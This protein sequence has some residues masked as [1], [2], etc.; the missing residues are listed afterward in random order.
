MAG[1]NQNGNLRFNGFLIIVISLIPASDAQCSPTSTG[2]KRYGTDCKYICHC[3]NNEQCHAVTGYCESGCDFKLVG[4]GCQFKNIAFD[5]ASRHIDNIG[6]PMYSHL[7]ND[8]AV[9]TCS[10]TNTTAAGTRRT[11]APWW[12]L[13]LPYAATFRKLVFVTRENYLPYFPNFKLI[14]QNVSKSDFERKKYSTEGVLCYQHDASI[15]QETTVQVTCTGVP[16]GNLIRL[17][18]ANTSTQLVICDFRVYEGCDNGFFGSDCSEHCSSTCYPSRHFTCDNIEGTCLNGCVSGWK[19][20][21]CEN[22]CERGYWGRDCA[23][24]CGNCFSATCNNTNGHCPNGC[25]AG[26]KRTDLC[27]EKC[28]NGY[29]GKDCK[30][31]CSSTCVRSSWPAICDNVNGSCLEG[32]TAGWKGL[33][34]QTTCEEGR[35]G[36]GCANKCGKCSFTTC[37]NVNGECLNGC[38]GGF[39]LTK[40][41]DQE[42]DNGTYGVNCSSMCSANCNSVCNK[43]KGTCSPCKAGWKGTNCTTECEPGKWG[44]NCGKDCGK[45]KS[46][47][48]CN[49]SNGT[50]FGGK[51][52]QGY[53]LTERCDEECDA[54]TYGVACKQNCSE[55]CAETCSIIDGKCGRCHTGWTGDLCVLQVTKPSDDSSPVAAIAGGISGAVVAAIIAVGLVLFVK[56]RRKQQCLFNFNGFSQCFREKL[57]K[58]RTANDKQVPST[59]QSKRSKTDEASPT[60][61]SEVLVKNVR[62]LVTQDSVHTGNVDCNVI[63]CDSLLNKLTDSSRNRMSG[64]G[65]DSQPS[66][67]TDAYSVLFDRPSRYRTYEIALRR[68]AYNIDQN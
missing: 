16:I 19:G 40:L 37:N 4:P 34:C 26:F 46:E 47:S 44:I 28:S 12:T 9:S 13:W 56:N 41:C 60:E 25:D 64:C 3:I 62:L 65:G 50:C 43:V 54:G 51:C 48:T 31:E 66:V 18:L 68:N 45:C 59:S 20:T 11:V 42:C 6:P 35:W 1:Q 14:V 30:G 32:C 38:V 58:K 63:D 23:E 36:N 27:T 7:A 8:D 29:Y 49:R 15:P 10:F 39:K 33:Q 55:R 24:T 57:A 22:E 21:R 52:M 5:E 61:N 53:K 67:A 17:Q 2:I